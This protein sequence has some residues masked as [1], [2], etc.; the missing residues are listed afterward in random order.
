MITAVN[1]NFNFQGNRYLPDSG[2][3]TVMHLVRQA[4]KATKPLTTPNEFSSTLISALRAN[5]G[6]FLTLD[7]LRMRGAI[8]KE[9][10]VGIILNKPPISLRVNIENGEIVEAKKPWYLGWKKT[11]KKVDE[12]LNYLKLNYNNPEVVEKKY[13]KK[14]LRSIGS[15]FKIS[16]KIANNKGRR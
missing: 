9:G 15:L 4:N 14:T 11:Y 6:E 12:F 16:A 3:K 1:S 5:L 7:S 8:N 2:V 10:E 13:V